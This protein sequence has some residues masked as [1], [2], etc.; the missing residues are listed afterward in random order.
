MLNWKCKEGIAHWFLIWIFIQL[1]FSCSPVG[2]RVDLDPV[3]GSEDG[4]D[5][6]DDSSSDNPAIKI[7]GNYQ[8]G[9]DFSLESGGIA[10]SIHGAAFDESF[11]VGLTPIA[12]DALVTSVENTG[13]AVARDDP[14]AVLAGARTDISNSETNPTFRDKIGYTYTLEEIDTEGFS[15]EL[16]QNIL[17][18]SESGYSIFVLVL[19]LSPD[20]TTIRS[21][22]RQSPTLSEDSSSIGFDVS[23]SHIGRGVLPGGMAILTGLVVI[24]SGNSFTIDSYLVEALPQSDFM[25]D[26]SSLFSSEGSYSPAASL[27]LDTGG[28]MIL[29]VPGTAFSESCEISTTLISEDN[30]LAEVTSAGSGIATNRTVAVLSPS[31]TI[32]SDS[33][34]PVTFN[35]SLNYAY[36]LASISSSEMTADE[37]A[38]AINGSSQSLSI[39]VLIVILSAD[40]SEVLGALNLSPGLSTD[41][42]SV[43]FSITQLNIG[44]GLIA[45]GTVIL[46]GLIAVPENTSFTVD[47]VSIEAIDETSEVTQAGGN[48]IPYVDEDGLIL[49]YD[50]SSLLGDNLA[51]L[52]KNNTSGSVFGAVSGT[53]GDREYYTFDGSDDYVIIEGLDIAEDVIQAATM[54]V[55]YRTADATGGY[56]FNINNT[57]TLFSVL[58]DNQWHILV[59][60]YDG[61]TSRIYLDGVL[62]NETE[63]TIEI[64][65]IRHDDIYIG[66]YESVGADDSLS[67]DID[68]L[69]IYNYQKSNQTICE[70]AGGTWNG[71][72]C[73]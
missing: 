73:I 59:A 37:I 4:E 6:S 16:I 49:Y 60:T 38:A 11:E 67:A 8:S 32:I 14:V 48:P 25:A 22:F 52:S 47:E 31:R 43:I 20:G 50:F 61:T 21:L 70:D 55:D 69:K 51:D 19:V 34:T 7:T 41:L 64:T 12:D 29:E 58:S 13:V 68:Y 36:D 15:A 45:G 62:A 46:S 33:E 56:V 9:V 66:S 30:F 39:Y 28:G 10:I 23:T 54:E 3:E 63:T 42:S 65:S 57:T 27:E 53:E 44:S 5:Q 1:Q 72:S 40:S 2:E 18:G 26:P 71:S 35:D 17:G 24:P